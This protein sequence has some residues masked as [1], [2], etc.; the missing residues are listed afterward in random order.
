MKTHVRIV[1][2]YYWLKI[3]VAILRVETSVGQ[4]QIYRKQAKI[5]QSKP[6]KRYI[7]IAVVVY[8]A[9]RRRS[10]VCPSVIIFLKKERVYRMELILTGVLYIIEIIIPI[11]WS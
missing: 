11:V 2:Q 1:D 3:F 10:R 4:A 8:D 6:E 5:I 7:T 9:I